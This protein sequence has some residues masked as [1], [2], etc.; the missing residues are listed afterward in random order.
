M[1]SKETFRAAFEEPPAAVVY[2]KTNPKTLVSPSISYGLSYLEAC[3]KHVRSTFKCS[4]VYIVSSGTLSRETNKLELL[5][6]K[7]TKDGV[8][9]VGVK[10]GVR[11]HTP[12]SLIHI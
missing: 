5:I 11:P 1:S 3:S 12:L 7:L 8:E 2:S 10:K 4:R 6:E 9:V